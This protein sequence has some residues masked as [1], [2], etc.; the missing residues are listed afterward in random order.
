M[1][2]DG[3]KK[4]RAVDHFS[5]SHKGKGCKRR[6]AKADVKADSVNGHYSMTTEVKHDHLDDLMA[7][8]RMHREAASEARLDLPPGVA[9]MRCVAA[10]TWFVEV[11]YRFGV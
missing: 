4:L 11:R 6:R 2:P 5:W 10:G 9:R 1:R 8:M 3:T 7:S